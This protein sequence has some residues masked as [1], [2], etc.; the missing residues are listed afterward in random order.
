M[1]KPGQTLENTIRIINEAFHY[2]SIPYWLCFGGLWAL[3][4]NEGVI[5]DGDLD[6]CTYY[7]ADYE[8]IIKAIENGPGNYRLSKCMMSNLEDK[9]VYCSFDSTQGFPHICLSFWYEYDRYRYYCHDTYN[10]VNGKGVP[11]S[12]YV[13]R[14][15]PAW[16]VDPKPEN[17]I[18]S[19][20][21]G[22]NQAHKIR[23]PR[24]AGSILDNMYPSWAYQKQRYEIR[25]NQVDHARMASYH[26]G[27][28]VSSH[29]VHIKSMDDFNNRQ[30]IADE[31]EKSKVKWKEA[32]KKA[33]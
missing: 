33:V 20:W 12:G 31:L 11:P 21:P 14:G 15:V 24:F 9:A 8:K 16:T 30:L 2:S 13:F 5:P 19:E 22:I 6:L 18:E 32:L 17:F 29:E 4:K 3:I 23:V 10:E 26:K 27:G 25:L 7:G 28:A 1:L